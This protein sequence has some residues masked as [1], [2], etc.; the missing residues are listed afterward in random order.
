MCSAAYILECSK[1]RGQIYG[2]FTETTGVANT[3]RGELLGLMAIRL[4]LLSANRVKPQLTGSMEILSDC[5]GALKR[6]TSL[7]THRIP[8]RCRH[9]DILKTILVHCRGVSFTTYY[10]HVRAHQDDNTTFN[11]LSRRAQLNCICDHAAKQ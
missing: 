4:I 8:S 10:T 6:V 9:L 1:G 2:A 11:K 3:Y 5:L 7:P